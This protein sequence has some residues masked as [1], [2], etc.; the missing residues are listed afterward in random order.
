MLADAAEVTANQKLYLL[1]GGWN[2]LWTKAFP[3]NHPMAIA[4]G[5]L[6][7]WPLTDET[8][9]ITVEIRDQD[10][11][12]IAPTV[13]AELKVGRPVNLKQ[14]STQRLM[15]VVQGF[16]GIPRAG[17]YAVRAAVGEVTRSASFDADVGALPGR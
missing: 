10:G 3:T 6:V 2:Q 8:H 4:I 17:A 11:N 13:N 12:P 9:V 14:G 7:P 16:F 1:G 5:V 15:F